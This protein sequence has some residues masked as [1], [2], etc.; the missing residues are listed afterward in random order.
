MRVEANV[1][2]AACN[3]LRVAATARYLVRVGSTASETVARELADL[4]ASPRFAG[5]PRMV[6]GGGSNI[7]FA[8]D[9][10]GV[11]IMPHAG[12]VAVQEDA[13][14]VTVTAAAGHNWQRLVSFAVARGWGGIENLS[15]I[16]GSVG[17]AP[18]QNIGAYGAQLS[19]VFVDLEAVPL[20]GGEPR[21]MDAA[22]CAFG[23]RDS[24]FKYSLRDRMLITR[25][26]LRLHKRPRLN[27]EYAGVREELARMA[28]TEPTVA[29][30]S[31]AIVRLRRR[32]LPDPDTLPN[33]GSFFK[34]P[35]LTPDRFARARELV[36]GLAG[37]AVPGGYKVPAAQLIEACGLRGRR[38]G[39]AGVAERHALVL[40]NHGGATGAELLAAATAVEEAVGGRFAVRLEREVRVTG[41]EEE[42]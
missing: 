7:L 3:T 32:K 25:V 41:T 19:D 14:S 2:L 40:V 12:D 11:V 26:R 28:V 29:D 21:P 20:A 16:P 17:A 15:L 1:S 18:I 10:P 8:A 30:V 31:R 27:L 4:L 42:A 39:R 38:F 33:A 24:V 13:E 23:Y 36:P 22:A 6:L 35:V 34:N 9:F 37:V 5:L